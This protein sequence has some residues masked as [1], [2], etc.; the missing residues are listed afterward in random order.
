MGGSG[1]LTARG[2]ENA[3]ASSGSSSIASHAETA[4]QRGGGAYEAPLRIIEGAT[5]DLG[6][7]LLAEAH[8]G[9]Y[10]CLP[11]VVVPRNET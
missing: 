3:S 5:W 10:L 7:V 2:I 1:E 9:Q 4:W 8:E 6:S 11:A